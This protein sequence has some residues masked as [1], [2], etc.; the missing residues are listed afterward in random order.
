[1]ETIYK[2]EL[3]IASEQ[4]LRL[5]SGAEILS[6]QQQQQGSVCAWVKLDTSKPMRDR[7]IVICGTGNSI[8]HEVTRFIETIQMGVMVWHFFEAI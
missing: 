2:Y 8:E 4:F 3:K 7:K 1:M 6:I 5:P